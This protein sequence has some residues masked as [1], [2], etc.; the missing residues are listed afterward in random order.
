MSTTLQNVSRAI[1]ED[2][3]MKKIFNWVEISKLDLP[4][5]FI[6]EHYDCLNWDVMSKHQRFPLDQFRISCFEQEQ[7][8][9]SSVSIH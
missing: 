6:D 3:E 9:R 4:D 8:S 2:P 5:L 1:R 7:F